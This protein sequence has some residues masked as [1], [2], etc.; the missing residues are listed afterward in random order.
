MMCLIA[1]TACIVLINIVQYLWMWRY[2][3]CWL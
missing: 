3:W 1:T 2:C